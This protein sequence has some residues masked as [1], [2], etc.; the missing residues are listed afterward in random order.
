MINVIIIGSGAVAA[1]VCSY[2][3]D[4][5]N[6][7]TEKIYIVGFLDIDSSLFKANSIKYKFSQPFLGTFDSFNYTVD[8]K[9]IICFANIK[10]RLNFINSVANKNLSYFTIIHPSCIISNSVIIGD[11]NIIYPNS[12]IGPNVVIGNHNLITSYSFISHDCVVGSN[13][14][15]STSGLSGNVEIGDNNYFG[16]RATVIPGIKIGSNNLIQAGMVID[17]NIHDNET[18][19]YKYKERVRII[20]FDE[21]INI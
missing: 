20:N 8:T 15:F 16:I 7:R 4:I 10:F 2:I 5:N 9:F 12:I 14:I 18:I 1:E 17:K 6:S 21:N 19:F 11:G 3:S 13:N